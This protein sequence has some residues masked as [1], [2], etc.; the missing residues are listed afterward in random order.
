MPAPARQP[1]LADIDPTT[2][3]ARL[4][5]RRAEEIFTLASGGRTLHQLRHSRLTHLAEA[6]IQLP[7]LIAK[8][9]HTSLTSLQIYAQPT[10]DA[11][12]AATAALDPPPPPLNPPI[13]RVLRHCQARSRVPLAPTVC[14]ALRRESSSVVGSR[15]TRGVCIDGEFEIPLGDVRTG[16]ADGDA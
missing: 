12:A 7:I 3:R 9:R 13:S 11:V 4:S 8:S 6:G 14:S 5:Y 15:L 16:H 2:G 10:F 1:A